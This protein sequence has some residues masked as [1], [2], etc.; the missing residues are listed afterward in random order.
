M[1]NKVMLYAVIVTLLTT[2]LSWQQMLGN[3]GARSGGVRGSGWSSFMGNGSWSGG[4]G[5]HK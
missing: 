5:G 2:A 3:N 4:S 1:K